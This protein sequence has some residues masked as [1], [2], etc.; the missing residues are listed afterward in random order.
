MTVTKIVY[1]THSIYLDAWISVLTPLLY[2]QCLCSILTLFS[3]CLS[4]LVPV[5]SKQHNITQSH[6]WLFTQKQDLLPSCSIGSEGFFPDTGNVLTVFHSFCPRSGKEDHVPL[7]PLE[8]PSQMLRWTEIA[9]GNPTGSS[10]WE[11][12]IWVCELALCD[13]LWNLSMCSL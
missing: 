8:A 5:K 2:H 3:F 11:I 4:F 7:L 1:S 13:Y 9:A 10:S 6:W 12:S